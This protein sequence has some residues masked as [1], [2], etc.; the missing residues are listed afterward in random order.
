MARLAPF[1]LCIFSLVFLTQCSEK[2]SDDYTDLGISYT[3]EQKYDEAMEA[4]LKAIEKNPRNTQ[5]HYGL[6]G[7]YNYKKMLPQAEQA[8]KTAIQL[9]PTHYNAYYSL[10][11]TYELM[12]NKLKAEENF[13]RYRELKG[14]LDA[15][16]A[17]NAK[18][19]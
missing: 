14:K 5:A 4:F 17:K 3:N 11:F 19:E 1:I 7:I 10:G 15:I 2:S 18:G 13:Q 8:F 12:G 6:G 9:D 16:I